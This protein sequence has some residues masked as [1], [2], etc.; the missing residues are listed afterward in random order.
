[1]AKQWQDVKDEIEREID[2]IWFDEPAELTLGKQGI[3]P[4]GA[5]VDGQA[6]GSLVF[7]FADTHAL[8]NLVFSP[9]MYYILK[10]PAFN[11]DHCKTLFA[12]TNI[13]KCR[14]LGMSSGPGTKCPAAWLNLPKFHK[15]CTDIIDSY[16]SI[17]TK[18]EFTDL[19]WSWFNYVD[20]MNKWVYIVFPWEVVGRYMRAV[21]DNIP[22]DMLKLAKES[23]II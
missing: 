10:D 22:E 1:M 4:S 14:I 18:E 7:M 21:K 12:Q 6:F 13:N 9:P 8:G 11:L 15:F 20:R 2:K 17:K 19:L 3:F 5:G 23:G 16:D